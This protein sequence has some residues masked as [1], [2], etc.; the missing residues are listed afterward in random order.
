MGSFMS[1]ETNGPVIFL[2][3]NDILFT[4]K[5]GDVLESTY[6]IDS[7]AS[8]QLVVTFLPLKMQQ[9]INFNVQK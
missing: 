8:G 6:R 9:I 1:A 2:V 7:F 4:V 5:P 3:R